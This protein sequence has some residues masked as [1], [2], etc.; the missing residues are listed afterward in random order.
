MVELVSPGV[1]LLGSAASGAYWLLDKVL[2]PSAV[3]LGETL[4]TYASDRISKIFG[5]A[6]EI[7]DQIPDFEV[8]P[9]PPAF[10]LK[11]FQE[12]SFSEDSE[13]ITEMW[14]RILVN[15][16]GFSTSRLAFF[17][18]VL[19][20]MSQREVF[21]LEKF[22]IQDSAFYADASDFSNASESTRESFGWTINRA[23]VDG[24]D[25]VRSSALRQLD[26][27]ES[28]IGSRHGDEA[29]LFMGA[30]FKIR[31]IKSP[32]ALIESVRLRTHIDF[33]FGESDY[34]IHRGETCI[35]LV[36]LDADVLKYVVSLD[37]LRSLG[38]LEKSRVEVSNA[39]VNAE[40]AVY[41]PTAMG[42]EFLLACHG[43]ARDEVTNK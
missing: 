42:V 38:I 37:I 9:L 4:K 28:G 2:G 41:A 33:D 32:T 19:S 26:E 6:A 39:S 20:K 15:Y 34:G 12:S 17:M 8:E 30:A 3:A 29:Q 11:F 16:E 27:F 23:I 13:S 40:I 18:S 43:S 7:I 36:S 31:K 14:A 1:V 21:S 35:E 22:F 25:K 10:L 5:R 24:F